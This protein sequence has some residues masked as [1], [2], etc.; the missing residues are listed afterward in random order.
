MNFTAET[1]VLVQGITEPLGAIY[2]PR[3][4]SYGTQVLAGVCPGHGGKTLHGLPVFDMVEQAVE[5]VGMV[6]TTVLFVQPYLVLDA[7]LE[8]IAAGIS[9]IIV[10]TEGVPP[11]D[12]VRLIRE[13]EATETVTL[14]LTHPVL[15]CRGK[16]FW[17]LTLLNSILPVK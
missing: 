8:A 12:M 14:V 7:A 4:L 17:G 11:L 5:E 13:A 1:R 10:I 2:V 6:D 16:S 3:M 15:S 9:Q